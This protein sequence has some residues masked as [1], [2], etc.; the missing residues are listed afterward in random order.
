MQFIDSSIIFAE[1]EDYPSGVATKRDESKC[2]G[3]DGHGIVS[4]FLPHEG[5]DDQECPS[6][7]GTGLNAENNE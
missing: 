3:C 6:C 2:E 5:W 4:Q 1:P 7:N